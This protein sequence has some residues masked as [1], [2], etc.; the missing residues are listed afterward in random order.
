MARQY[1]NTAFFI[2][3]TVLSEEQKYLKE[4]TAP[5]LV[6]DTCYNFAPELESFLNHD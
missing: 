5:I 1:I 3:N 6:F 2:F 4:K